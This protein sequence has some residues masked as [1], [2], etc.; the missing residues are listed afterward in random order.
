MGI[1]LY[2]LGNM[3]QAHIHFGQGASLYDR[4]QHHRLAF[5]Y[6]EDP[7]VA[8]LSRLGHIVWVLGYPDQSLEKHREALALAQ[9]L[10]H[11]FSLAY[12]LYFGAR[13]HQFRREWNEILE[14]TQPLLDLSREQGFQFWLASGRNVRGAAL[15]M[16]GETEAGVEQMH[17]GLGA[18]LATG[19]QSG[20]PRELVQLAEAYGK[21]GQAAEGLH[22]LSAV[23]AL[24]EKTGERF[25]A[26]E[27]YRV[28]GELL[29]MQAAANAQEAETNFQ[30]ALN[31]ARHQQAKSW[32]LRA[33]L[34]LSRLWQQQGQRS[35]AHELLAPI[36]GWFTEGFDTADL[37]EAKA[38]LQE[39]S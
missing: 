31:I 20:Q 3:V 5:L 18:R 38:L 21:V 30:L 14:L 13:L 15:A 36:Y 28:K 25:A 27:C 4:G 9:D 35:E 37:Q 32:E 33:A 19:A 26:S 22:V 23:P 11:T 12:A 10:G 7:G 34:S 1:T 6:G 39:L 17:V 16:M 24:T 29:L 2:N 8:C